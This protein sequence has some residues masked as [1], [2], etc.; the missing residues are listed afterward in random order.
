[1]Q[2]DPAKQAGV[3]H[4]LA[5]CVVVS[6]HLFWHVLECSIFM[7]ILGRLVYDMFLQVTVCVCMHLCLDALQNRCQVCVDTDTVASL[8]SLQGQ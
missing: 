3:S 4:Q 1:M 5:A 7:I 8:T 2:V 6:L